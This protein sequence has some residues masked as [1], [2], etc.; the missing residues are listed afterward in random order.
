VL[1]VRNLRLL[2]L[3]TGLATSLVASEFLNLNTTFPLSAP[4][5]VHDA[6]AN[7][8]RA[9]TNSGNAAVWTESPTSPTSS[10]MVRVRISYATWSGATASVAN[11]VRPAGYRFGGQLTVGSIVDTAVGNAIYFLADNDAGGADLYMVPLT[12]ATGTISATKVVDRA[13][14]FR[15][16]EDKG[17]LLVAR[18]DGV[19]RYAPLA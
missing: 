17:R 2:D 8:G 7:F 6:N 3:T 10:N 4:H 14:W 5:C 13:Y 9:L 18:S 15:I 11:V 16:R 12:A 19:L 1:D